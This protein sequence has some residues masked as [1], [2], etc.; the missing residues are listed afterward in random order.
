MN[1]LQKSILNIFLTLINIWL[2]FVCLIQGL[3]IYMQINDNVI[4]IPVILYTLLTILFIFFSYMLI[5]KSKKLIGISIY[6][7]VLAFIII[8]PSY[9]E[10]LQK[11]EEVDTCL[12]FGGRW[13]Y[14]LNKCEGSRLEALNK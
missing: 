14:K 3:H 10:S 11:V 7:A 2:L 1:T 6:F 12:D 4:D 9:S 8:I 5:H 13:N